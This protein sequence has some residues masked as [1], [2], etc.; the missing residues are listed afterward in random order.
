[1]TGQF[2]RGD[3]GG[4]NF[5]RRRILEDYLATA[6]QIEPVAEADRAKL[7]SFGGDVKENTG[8]RDSYLREATAANAPP[9]PADLLELLATLGVEVM[10]LDKASP[11]PRVGPR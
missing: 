9:P 7:M 4:Q 11:N 2:S 1:M 6:G 10:P 3:E 8:Y 5:D